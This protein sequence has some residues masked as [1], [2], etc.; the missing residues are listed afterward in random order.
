MKKAFTLIEA[1]VYIAILSLII[2][3]VASVLLWSSRSNTKAKVIS[4]TT[5][6]ARR[7]IEVISHE[8][9]EARGIYT[10]TSLFATSSGQLSLET[11]NY[12]PTGE[13]TTHIDFFLC[14]EQICLKKENQDPISITSDN[15]RISWL[16]FNQAATTSVQISIIAEY[17][18]PSDKGEYQ[19]SI[20]ITSTAAI[21]VY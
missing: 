14:G 2:M 12:I 15:I 8:I 4:E 20:N 7:A 6:N 11:S 16:E 3:I 21:R 17:K 1:L 9:K 13:I 19:A 5:Y 10:P 18:T